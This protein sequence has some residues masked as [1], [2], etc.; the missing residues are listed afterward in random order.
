MPRSKWTCGL[1]LL[2]P[3]HLEAVL[4]CERSHCNEK[5][6]STASEGPLFVATRVK[7][8]RSNKEHTRGNEDPAQPNGK[9]SN[10]VKN[11]NG[12]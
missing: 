6:E 7:P 1:Q 9:Q 10:R 4:C 5:A 11:A 8:T 3:M 2:D 12:F